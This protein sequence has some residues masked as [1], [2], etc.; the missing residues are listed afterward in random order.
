MP[1]KHM[2]KIGITESG[3]VAYNL[4][5]FDRLCDANIIITK[6]L[7]DKLIN[8]L[9]EN[10]EKCILHLTCTGMGGSKLEPFVPTL[11]KTFEQFTKLIDKG[12]PVKHVVLRIDPIVP[13]TKGIDTAVNVLRKFRHSGI[14]RCRY[15]VMDMYQHVK[16][17]F[18]ENNI[19]LPYES[20]HAPQINRQMC[21]AALQLKCQFLGMELEACGEP[22]IESISCISQKDVDILGVDIELVGEKQQRKTCHCPANKTELIKGKPHRCNNACLYCFWKNE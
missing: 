18:A 8:K 2:Q 22:D 3:E 17:R 13:T 11:D 6:S 7:T 21:H 15:S 12:F 16:E 1:E 4:D 14:T 5:V 9:V 20:F 19:P 10:K